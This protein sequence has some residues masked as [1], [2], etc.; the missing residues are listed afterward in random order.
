MGNG[1]ALRRV[2]AF[3]LNGDGVAAE[4]VQV[5]FGIGLLEQLA[6]LG[7]GRDGVK[8]AGVGDARLGVVADELV[9]VG[10][11]A[12]A[13]IASAAFIDPSQ[14]KIPHIE[15]V[16]LAC[17]HGCIAGGGTRKAHPGASSCCF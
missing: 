14:S 7:R 13:W 3:R 9:A 5:A 17:L 2:L 8:H 11:N 15:P 12:D 4:D 1:S 6:A 16:F 10:G